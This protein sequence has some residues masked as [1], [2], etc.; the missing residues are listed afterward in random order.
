MALFEYPCT[1]PRKSVYGVEQF[2]LEPVQEYDKIREILE[3]IPDFETA[4]KWL[5]KENFTNYVFRVQTVVENDFFMNHNRR[6]DFFNLKARNYEVISGINKG[7]R[8]IPIPPFQVFKKVPPTR[9]DWYFKA[10]HQ[11]WLRKLMYKQLN[12][13]NNIII[14]S[15]GEEEL[16]VQASDIVFNELK[17]HNVVVPLM[18][19]TTPKESLSFAKLTIDLLHYSDFDLC[20]DQDIFIE[21][22]D[23]LQNL[24]IDMKRKLYHIFP[25]EYITIPL[26]I[27]NY[28][29]LLDKFYQ[30]SVDDINELRLTITN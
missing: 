24:S 10:Q 12:N 1:V 18:V 17:I 15:A 5:N 14:F 16:T 26:H 30:F 23:I 9:T 3:S 7:K 20:L 11:K 19:L 28:F 6:D 27:F 4:K 8:E 25:E 29:E 22:K 13:R 2:V 21:Y